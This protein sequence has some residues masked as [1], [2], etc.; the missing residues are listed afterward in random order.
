M[1]KKSGASMLQDLSSNFFSRPLTFYGSCEN[2]EEELFEDEWNEEDLF[3]DP[4]RIALET[5][6]LFSLRQKIGIFIHWCE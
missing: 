1:R 5:E 3:A 6:L 2:I 4:W